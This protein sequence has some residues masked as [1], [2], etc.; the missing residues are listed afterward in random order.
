MLKVITDEALIKKCHALFIRSFK[1]FIDRKIPVSLGH[2]GASI[3]AK[4]SWSDR[5]G[6]WLFSSRISDN[7]YWNAFG[8]VRSDLS[9]HIPITCEIN[10]P[11]SGID[12]RIGGVMACDREGRV[13]IV[14]RGKIGG[15]KKGIGKSLF[16]NSYRGSWTLLDEGDGES[17]VALI[18]EL[19][20]PRFVRQVTQ[21][22]RKVNAIKDS[23]SSSS[24]QLTFPFDHHG[25]REELIGTGQSSLAHD[26]SSSCDHG[27]AVHDLYTLLKREGFRPRNGASHDLFTIGDNGGMETIFSVVAE[28]EERAVHAAAMR[29]LIGAS[30][31]E[32]RPSLVLAVPSTLDRA[33]LNGLPTLGIQIATYE[34]DGNGQAVFSGIPG[35]N[36]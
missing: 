28:R 27:L 35:L 18:G 5:L 14:H 24:A 2:Q 33:L 22:I 25:L 29:L 17:A 12:R 31:C 10:F 13:F 4:V 16:E 32:R 26:E 6:V 21:F 36:K 19:R 3:L 9:S 11:S 30:G 7:R 15:G 23:A 20:S 34:W 8:I 1:P